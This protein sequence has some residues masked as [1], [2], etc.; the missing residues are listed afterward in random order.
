MSVARSTREMCV[1]T[2]M[3]ATTLIAARGNRNGNG[4][5]AGFEFLVDDGISVLS[6]L[7]NRLLDLRDA[8]EGFG[9][10]GPRVEIVQVRSEFL[11]GQRGKQNPSHR[12]AVGRQSA[13]D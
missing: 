1:P 10:V 11:I 6:H 3:A 2:L 8:G 13:A 9:C 4:P 5:Q 7:E 12:R